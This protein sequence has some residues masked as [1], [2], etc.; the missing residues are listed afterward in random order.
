MELSPDFARTLLDAGAGRTRPAE[1]MALSN[2][3]LEHPGAATPWAQKF[4]EPAYLGYFLPLNYARVRAV[5]R[6]VERF[7]PTEALGAVVDY[8]SGSGAVQFALEDALAPRPLFCVERSPEARAVH[9][10]LHAAR[11][12][13]WQPQFQAPQDPG[14][15]ALAIFSYAFL[16]MQNDL[17]D[18][19][20]FD[21]LLIIEPSTRDCGRQLMTWRQRL[22][23]RGYR[24][25]AP[26]T[27]DAA[28]PLL[29]ESNKDWCHHRVEF[30][31]PSWWPALEDALP[32]K[33]RTLTYSYLLMSPH[34]H[35][36]NLARRRARD[37]RHHERAGKNAAT[38]VP[39]TAP[40][41][42]CRG[43]T[44][45]VSPRSS[46]AARCWAGSSAPNLRAASCASPPTPASK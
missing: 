26:C 40:R 2:F 21:H 33:N 16:E 43:C 15:G 10:R 41:N 45:L 23:E 38:R 37:R 36:P 39:R 7:V 31:G 35:R 29:V 9:R 4:T 34:R 19:G 1:V 13:R 27:H 8:G 46:R 25:L 22:I 20:R 6:E 42:F 3:Y 44:A 11:G 32:M 14:A 30:T 5:L 17:P 12:G 24:A 18:L 28:C